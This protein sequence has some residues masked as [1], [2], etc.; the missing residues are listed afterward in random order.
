MNLEKHKIKLTA[1]LNWTAKRPL[2]VIEAKLPGYNKNKSLNY[3]HG[4]CQIKTHKIN[5]GEK[6][7][8]VYK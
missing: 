1:R 2:M 5:H 8:F 7:F 6:I 3:N 4:Q